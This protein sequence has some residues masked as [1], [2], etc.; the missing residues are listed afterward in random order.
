MKIRITKIIFLVIILTLF[1]GCSN[2][3]NESEIPICKIE[4]CNNPCLKY[5]IGHESYYSSYCEDHT[6]KEEGCGGQKNPNDDYCSLHIEEQIKLTDSQIEEVK[7]LANKYFEQLIT[8][9]SNILAI[10]M[11]N[12]TPKTT[13][14]NISFRCNIVREDS[15]T[16]LATLYIY[17]TDDG[18]FK[19]HKLE[20]D[21]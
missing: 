14:N 13:K 11:I 21:K 15:D 6:C 5:K 2:N 10:N 20:Y 17:I 12:D 8:K 19:V 9:Q 18:V 4:N 7:E 1:S 16:N 3:K